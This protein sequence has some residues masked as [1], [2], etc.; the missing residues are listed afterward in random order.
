M[1]N[2]RDT[3]QTGFGGAVDLDSDH[4]SENESYSLIANYNPATNE[5]VQPNNGLSY[6]V[7]S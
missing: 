3:L 7:V 4:V 1:Q 6:S 5:R 2:G